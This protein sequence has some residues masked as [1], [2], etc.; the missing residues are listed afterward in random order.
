MINLLEKSRYPI[1]VFEGPDGCGKTSLAHAMQEYLGARYIHLTYRWKD[2]MHLYH[3]AAIRV[4][5][6]LAQHQPV[7]ID[8]WWPSEIIYAEAYRGGSKFARHFLLLEH[9]ANH[10]G[11]VYVVCL[12]DDRERYLAHYNELK[13]KRAEMYDT[14]LER[15]Y[16]GYDEF[17]KSYLGIKEN[18]C[19]YDLFKNFNDNV[20]SRR[21]VMREVCQNILE[22]AEDHRSSIE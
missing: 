15:V 7:L 6:H 3:Y 19:R 21:I 5:A 17:Y 20:V 8:R 4:A 16:D 13:G 11:L 10:I 1:I 9:I 22:F 12:P 18:A 2:K 14:G